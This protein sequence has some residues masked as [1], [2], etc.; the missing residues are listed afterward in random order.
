MKHKH[1]HW[2]EKLQVE[3]AA[4]AALALTFFVLGPVRG[5]WDPQWPTT[6][7][8]TGSFAALCGFAITVWLI[9]AGCG[10]LTI[11]SRPEGALFATLVGAMGASFHSYPMRGMIWEYDGRI[12]LLYGVLILEVMLLTVVLAVAAQVVYI[13]RSVI[14]RWRPRWMWRGRVRPEGPGAE[15]DGSANE[16]YVR[17]T[18]AERVAAAAFGSLGVFF[19][20][21]WSGKRKLRTELFEAGACLG[22]TILIAS[23]L[24]LLLM[25]STHRGQIIFALFISFLLSTLIAHQR[26]ATVMGIV[27]WLAPVLAALLFYALAA[28]SFGQAAGSNV[29]TIAPY[30][31]A[32][33]VDWVTAGG[34]GGVLGYW[35]SERIHEFRHIEQH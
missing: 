33:P 9:A 27:S 35:I 34:A 4:A 31:R 10:A 32:L 29:P 18:E 24:T 5:S 15:K 19:W 16:S 22:V 26:F 7:L 30:A 14:A 1:H 8:P 28:V 13:V 20:R 23:M 21:Q 25:Q 11:T 12:G 2:L 17:L 3:I 6:F